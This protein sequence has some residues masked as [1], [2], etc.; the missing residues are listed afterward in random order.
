MAKNYEKQIQLAISK[1]QKLVTADEAIIEKHQ[2]DL[3]EHRA[4]LKKWKDMEAKFVKLQKE[5]DS[6]N[7]PNPEQKQL[8]F[9]DEN[10]RFRR[11]NRW[12]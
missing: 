7:S 2:K 6:L 12:S 5:I 8:D 4:E 1:Y 9:Y 11:K 3:I 10:A